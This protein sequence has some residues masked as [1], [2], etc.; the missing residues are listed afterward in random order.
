MADASDSDSSSAP[1]SPNRDRDWY[2]QQWKALCDELG[3][4]D[5][6][7]VL[8]RVQTLKRQMERLDE[9][10][11][12]DEGLVTI[13][14]VENVF[15]E[16]NE[17]MENLRE[18]NSALAERLEGDED[19]DSAFRDLHQKAEQ[20]LNALDAATMDEARDRIQRLNRRL[21]TL[22]QEKE[23]LVQ[24]GHETA[25]DALDELERL[26]NE[27]DAL[28]RERDQLQ[29]ERDQLQQEIEGS[30]SSPSPDPDTS[31]LEAAVV[32][33]DRIGVSTPDQAES[34][35]RIAEQ[36]YDRVCTY[37]AGYDADTEDAPEDVV[38]MLHGMTA[39][40]DALPAPDAFPP[41]AADALGIT[42]SSEAHTLADTARRI[43]RRLVDHYEGA[44][45]FE[46][47]EPEGK[48]VLTL[49]HSLEDQ[50]RALPAPDTLS[51]END[52]LPAEAGN[53]LGIRTVED[54]RE[55]DDL[56]AEM[57]DRLDHLQ[58]EHQK[59]DRVGLSV[60]GVLTMVDSMS[61]QLAD[62]YENDA[63]HNDTA[64][65]R[66][67]DTLDDALAHRVATL[68]D[69][70]PEAADDLE[71]VV[72]T[73]VDELETLSNEYDVLAEAGY[74]AEE[75]VSLIDNMQTQLDELY[76]EKGA[77]QNAQERL[78]AI[79]DVLGISS[80]A[81]AEE[82]SQLAHQMEEQLTTLYREKEKLE[83]L[84][85]SSVDDAVDMIESME[86]QLDEL[87]D[88]KEALR[89]VQLGSTDEQST[90][91]QLEALYAERQKLQQ[92]L[93]VSSAEDVI[94][95][96]ESLNTQ[97]DDLYTGRDADVS[98][99]ERHEARLWAPD[100]DSL[101]PDASSSPDDASSDASLEREAADTLTMNSMEH[102]LEALYRE[103]ET[104]LHHGFDNAQEAVSQLE[105]QQKQIDALQR[106]N[107]TY[108]R[109]FD[110]L[111]SELGTGSVP[112][113]VEGI[114][115]LESEA[116]TTLAEL[117]PS[118]SGPSEPTEYGVDIEAASPFVD[119]TTLDR[120][121]EMTSDELDALDV[122]IIQLRDDGTVASLN[123]A[124][125]R[126]PGLHDVEDPAD[127][128][129]EN[130]F[131]DLAPSTNNNLFFGRFRKGQRQG[132]MDARFPY[133]FVSPDNG[134]QSFSVHLYRAPEGDTTWL[135][136]RPA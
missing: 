100:T 36:V 11:R 8:A 14:E 128:I 1:S 4:S 65:D 122:G 6:N 85:L 29:A 7:E 90:F 106:E 113:V 32:I 82:L 124:A 56:I 48:D 108:E 114:H 75:A 83:E 40:L 97:L 68:T 21:E 84:G 24:A 41:D 95:M 26:R 74:D 60:D 57:S 31:V 101:S 64:S 19:I 35:R 105:T 22:Y 9:G 10:N 133:T 88:D 33:R 127:V 96:V 78:S 115:A 135:L 94:E 45:D 2:V 28:K 47:V 121:D 104:L 91:Q 18:R 3:T 12:Q 53:I 110:Q 118:L 93:G 70:S 102:Q 111:Q 134:P 63:S 76:Q 43:G 117:L 73:L 42:T 72:R 131:L 67:L 71:T 38:E 61:A 116:D 23:Q 50:L 107:R 39:Q 49:L 130:F 34:L 98:P 89:E 129:G 58:T 125:F 66:G 81:E 109:R 103:K 87:Y 51:A 20:L 25:E 77:A 80:R 13:S 37:A 15:Q 27:R 17:K 55:L 16:M 79:E 59:L 112:K 44:V 120:L 99:E 46:N 119:E 30:T 136:F 69:P 54:A 62:L 132:E 126:L 86:Q 52:A 123:E 92:A 5:P